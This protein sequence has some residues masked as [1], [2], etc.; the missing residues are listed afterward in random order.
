MVQSKASNINSLSDEIESSEPASGQH[1]KRLY[2][3]LRALKDAR[4]IGNRNT[5]IPNDLVVHKAVQ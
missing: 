4:N 2:E 5:L 3:I 1:F